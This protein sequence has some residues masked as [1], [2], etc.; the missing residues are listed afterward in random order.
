[1]YYGCCKYDC[2]ADLPMYD[3]NLLSV[4]AFIH[5][6]LMREEARKKKNKDKK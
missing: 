1:M 4:N 6:E 2:W 5:S 3:R